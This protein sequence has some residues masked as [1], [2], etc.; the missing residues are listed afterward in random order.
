[1]N[2]NSLIAHVKAASPTSRQ[3]QP[4]IQ[5]IPLPYPPPSAY[6]VIANSDENCAGQVHIDSSSSSSSSSP[7]CGV[8]SPVVVFYNT[9]ETECITSAIGAFFSSRRRR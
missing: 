5:I 3:Q 2:V 8:V 1:M 9:D 7:S 4:T 6:L